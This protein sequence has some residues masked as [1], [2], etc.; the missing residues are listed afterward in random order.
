MINLLVSCFLEN[1][2][3][4]MALKV[5]HKFPWDWWRCMDGSSPTIYHHCPESNSSTSSERNSS[6]IHTVN[7]ERAN[8]AFIM[9][10]SRD[11]FWGF[12][13]NTIT[14][15]KITE[16]IPKQF[17]FGNSSTQIQKFRK[18]VGGQRGLAR[19]TPW[20]ARGSGLFS[21]PFF[22]CPL[23]RRGTHFWRTFCRFLRV[24]LSPT[25]S[26]QPLFETSDKL[27]NRIPKT[28][29]SGIR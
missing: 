17:R 3:G 23:R 7:L 19:W 10:F 12:K 22:L 13:T 26:R 2:H 18:G 24:C 5:C 28:I 15:K 29:R 20:C 6:P 1:Q 11:H 21:V 8:S 4:P 27:P 14:H 9:G 16:L 25:S